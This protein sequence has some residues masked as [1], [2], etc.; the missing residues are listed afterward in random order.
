MDRNA[1]N[2][3]NL[4]MT[5]VILVM[6]TLASPR[7]MDIC[8]VK[9]A[10]GKLEASGYSVKKYENAVAAW[11]IDH[12]IPSAAIE[13]DTDSWND[14]YYLFEFDDGS[15]AAVDPWTGKIIAE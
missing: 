2:A 6:V 4:L 7:I 5:F 9:E 8:T 14:M 13:Q 1:V 12:F 3:W 15:Y 10:G 11:W